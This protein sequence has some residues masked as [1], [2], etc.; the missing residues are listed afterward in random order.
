MLVAAGAVGALGMAVAQGKDTQTFAAD[1]GTAWYA[2]HQALADLQL[3]VLR[4]SSD[5]FSGTVETATGQGQDVT[6]RL[7]EETAKFQGD[8]A[9]TR[10]SIRVDYFG[11]E[12]VT[13]RIFARI[14]AHVAAARHVSAAGPA[15][16][17]LPPPLPAGP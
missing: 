4:Q 16:P 11:D 3:P 2:T 9:R 14:E 13:R 7:K 15:V 5:A 6:I 8:P 17:P 12:E 10:V 1:F